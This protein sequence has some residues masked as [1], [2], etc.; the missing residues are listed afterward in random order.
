MAKK[1]VGFIG[2]IFRRSRDDDIPALGGQMAYFMVLAFFP[3]LS[4]LV[5]LIGYSPI[6]AEQVL[7]GLLA[8]LPEEAYILVR[9]TVIEVVDSSS[10][11]LVSFSGLFALW[12]ASNGIGAIIKGLNKA[13]DVDEERSYLRVRLISIIFTLLLSLVIVFS[14]ILLIFGGV[15]KRNLIDGMEM[16]I[17][18]QRIWN[19][20]R[21]AFISF[22]IFITFLMM[23]KYTP[24]RRV[25]WKETIPGAVFATIGWIIAS[26]GFAYYVDNY[27]H[28]SA[29]YGGIGGMAILL[30]WLYLSAIVIL[31]GGEINGALIKT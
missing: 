29:F 13:Y 10:G 1:S 24:N 19:I 26:M 22:V 23:Y 9:D 3:F 8:I 25:K 17:P 2:R 16:L 7:E 31:V 20:G 12:L 27:S 6:S 15:I 14:F 18:Y 4:F 11:S 21:F 28:Y 30:I 5:S